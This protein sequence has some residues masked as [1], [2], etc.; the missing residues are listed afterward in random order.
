MGTEGLVSKDY[1]FE[2]RNIRKVEYEKP[3]KK[4]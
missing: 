1:K 3:S 4:I 2:F